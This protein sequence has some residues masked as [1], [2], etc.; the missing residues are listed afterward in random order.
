M[1]KKGQNDF[2][3]YDLDEV[4]QGLLTGEPFWP[5]LTSKSALRWQDAAILH[6]AAA[7]F[8]NV[9]WNSY[10]YWPD[11]D[12]YTLSRKFE[13][14]KPFYCHWD[15]EYYGENYD[16]EVTYEA[17]PGWM[18]KD[19]LEYT[20][21]YLNDV[22]DRTHASG[23]FWWWYGYYCMP[24][25]LDYYYWSYGQY[26]VN[27]LIGT[28]MSSYRWSLCDK[29]Y[30]LSEYEDLLGWS[31]G[32]IL[33]RGGAVKLPTSP[34]KLNMSHRTST[35]GSSW[36]SD[37]SGSYNYDTDD[38]DDTEYY[39]Q[40][41]F[42]HDGE[43][44]SFDATRKYVQT[45][46][47]C[48]E[49]DLTFKL[50]GMK[51]FKKD[52]NDEFLGNGLSANM[53]EACYDVV[54]ELCTADALFSHGTYYGSSRRRNRTGN[55]TFEEIPDAV[56]ETWYSQNWYWSA[57]LSQGTGWHSSDSD[58]G[59]QNDYKYMYSYDNGEGVFRA[60]GIAL[61]AF[62]SWYQSRH[63][64]Q[65][66]SSSGDSDGDSSGTTNYIH[67]YKYFSASSSPE[68][69]TSEDPTEIDI[70]SKLVFGFGSTVVFQKESGGTCVTSCRAL[71]PVSVYVNEYRYKSESVNNYSDGGDSGE[72]SWDSHGS[73]DSESHYYNGTALVPLTLEAFE[74]VKNRTNRDVQLWTS[75]ETVSDVVEA[76]MKILGLSWAWDKPNKPGNTDDTGKPSRAWNCGEPS[77]SS[78]GGT[79]SSYSC[80]AYIHLGDRN[81]IYD[82]ENQVYYYPYYTGFAY[83]TVALVKFEPEM[84]KIL[85]GG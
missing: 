69:I 8:Y 10:W 66:T 4:Q 61:S 9:N 15:R 43:S 63:Q 56:P 6:D 81:N 36:S 58:H 55:S 27:S 13:L 25:Q 30:K 18:G 78:S 39:P 71:F 49:S 67:K 34:I 64:R 38:S 21:K 17:T 83:N 37:S 14:D 80:Y 20:K 74:S 29:A 5:S 41:G 82:S 3:M 65:S 32:N 48:D 45:I 33:V 46:L 23:R 70:S 7:F 53:I 22:F 75:K 19:L 2:Q 35:W 40:G 52:Y 76:A 60:A 11:K 72:S 50:N 42:E 26:F 59:S 1:Y 16:Q 68:E 54:E 12:S 79:H 57:S 28:L 24:P 84:K 47:G 77:G 62:L 31:Y 51:I 73:S 85:F 44:T